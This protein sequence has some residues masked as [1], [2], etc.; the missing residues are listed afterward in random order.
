MNYTLHQL[1][2]FKEVARTGSITKAAEALHLTQPAISIQLNKLEEQFELALLEPAGR[3]VRMTDFG[4]RFL[5]GVERLILEAE[6]LTELEAA[7][8]KLLTGK[9]RVAVVS[10]GKYV[11]P[12]LLTGFMRRHPGIEL[13]MEVTNRNAVVAQLE[14]G[15]VDFALVSILPEHLPLQSMAVLNNELYLVRSP[16]L[17]RL[18]EV[19]DPLLDVPM[20]FREPGSG[21]RY[22]T[23][24]F[25][26]ERSLK[27]A[28]RME[29]TSNEAVKQAVIAGLG[30][31]IMPLIGL[32]NELKAGL[33]EVVDYPG[34]PMVSQWQLV[35]RA[36]RKPGA[37]ARGF[38][39]WLKAG[40]LE[41]S[42][43]LLR[44]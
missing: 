16:G 42:L 36:D 28:R 7:H 9:L 32:K 34:L 44:N 43:P 13:R 15:S 24:Q 22:M 37:A 2:I 11:M 23:E 25:L 19:D 17:V 20:I 29:L 10:T 14:E 12:Y 6:A 40:G 4:Q 8:R 33:L 41:E 21:T 35:W 31:S 1:R 3:G 26:K 27:P 39:Q 30:Q 5:E 18:P 38:E